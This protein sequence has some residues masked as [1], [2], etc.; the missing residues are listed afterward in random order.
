MLNFATENQT[1][2]KIMANGLRYEIPRFQRDYAWSYEQWQDLW[3]DLDAASGSDQHYMGYLVFQSADNK[4]FS[5]I[6]G[7]QRLTTVSI[8]IVAALRLLRDIIERGIEPESNRQRLDQLRN[9]YIGFTDSVT[10]LAT[11]KLTLNVNNA[12]YYRTYVVTFDDLPVRNITASERQLQ[13]AVAF[14]EDKIAGAIVDGDGASIA[15]FVE[16]LVDKLLFTTITVGN[17]LNAYRVFETLNAR[18]VQLSVPDLLKNYLFSLIDADSPIGRTELGELENRW[19]QIL[20]QL[21]QVDFTRFV[22]ADWNS[23]NPAS[24]RSQLFRR[25]KAALSGREAAFAYI[26][27]LLRNAQV[28]AALHNYQDEFWKQEGY[29]PAAK[30]IRTLNMFNVR[31]PFSMLLSVHAHF[32]AGRFCR[33]VRV[34]EAVSMR[35]NV[36]GSRQANVQESTYNRI[37]RD[38]AAGRVVNVQQ[39]KSAIRDLYVSDEDFR[40]EFAAKS[41]KTAQTRKKA[42]YILARLEECETGHAVSDSDYTLEH[43]LPDNPTGDW[44]HAFGSE[45]DACIDRIGNLC[46]LT[47]AENK[48]VGRKAFELKKDVFADSPLT[49]TRDIAGYTAWNAESVEA[50]QSRLADIALRCWSVEFS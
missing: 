1:F 48:A 21:G 3:E 27:T 36:I 5:V 50:R 38:V 22:L 13:K 20:R 39:F 41:L 24:N 35:Y 47:H 42:R 43:V 7:Q 44:V 45:S 2:R 32:E 28:Y 31:Q 4:T 23:R 16:A 8:M 25:L 17:D 12:D 37:A 10:L 49:L 26:R 46:L 19:Q 18:G 9:S 15:A 34:L 30:Y 40:S 6:D 29:A 14:F 33:A 11:P